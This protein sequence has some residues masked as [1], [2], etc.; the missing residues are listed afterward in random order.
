MYIEC[1]NN[2]IL[3]FEILAN[4]QLFKISDLK[5]SVCIE[6]RYLTK[7]IYQ[8]QPN[9]ASVIT[10][11]YCFHLSVNNKQKKLIR[12]QASKRKKNI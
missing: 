4:L 7:Q 11:F 9:P 1:N 5:E 3:F 10:I 12:L 6:M 2:F 8:L